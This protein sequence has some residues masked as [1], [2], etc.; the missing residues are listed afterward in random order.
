MDDGA[1]AGNEFDIIFSHRKHEDIM[2][3]S[4]T[5]RLIPHRC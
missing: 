1:E 4:V 2:L 3:M 5:P